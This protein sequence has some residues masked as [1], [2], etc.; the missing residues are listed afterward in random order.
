MIPNKLLGQNFIRCPWVTSTM[1]K[2]AELKD[3]DTVLEVGAGTGILTKEMLKRARTVIAVEKDKDLIVRY[4]RPL[5]KDYKN[6]EIIEG[7]ILKIFPNLAIT[8]HLEPKTYKLVSNIP[9]YLTS[10]LLRVLLEKEP[11]PHTIV[12][13][14]QKEVAERICAKPNYRSSTSIG[15]MNLLAISVQ[16]FG[17]PEIIKKVPADCF[18]PKPK[19]DSAIIKI[20]HISDDFFV[21]NKISSE[22]FFKII[23]TAFS[24]KRKMLINTLAV[25]AG[26]KNKARE[27]LT[28]A[29]L[30]E[31]SRPEELGLEHW[32]K[33]VRS[34]PG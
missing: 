1:L 8:Y 17:K 30:S 12:L 2:A 4:L 13:T 22:N 28:I 11:R 34:A 6:L 26:D 20:D 27:L 14:V 31:K 21:K 33:L 25:L 23:K 15:K 10:H 16:T 29:G 24:S 9:Y 5:E 7:D 18:W 19:V 3:S 32:A